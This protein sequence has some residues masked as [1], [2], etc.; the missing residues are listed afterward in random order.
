MFYG[1][2]KPTATDVIENY[3]EFT[4]SKLM[5]KYQQDNQ[6]FTTM[7]EILKYYQAW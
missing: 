6:S 4:N 3:P 7:K 5:M 2:T 1:Q